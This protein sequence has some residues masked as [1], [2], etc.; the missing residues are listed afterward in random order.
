MQKLE[1]MSPIFD[2]LRRRRPSFVDSIAIQFPELEAVAKG[3]R[4]LGTSSDEP[5]RVDLLSTPVFEIGE[6]AIADA[7]TDLGELV[8]QLSKKTKVLARIRLV[9][10]IMTALTT[11]GVLAAVLKEQ[12]MLEVLTAVIA[13]LCAMASLWAIYIEDLSGGEGTVTKARDAAS[14]GIG[15]LAEAEGLLTLAKIMKDGTKALAALSAVNEVAA[16]SQILRAR[17]GLA[18]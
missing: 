18:I 9:S 5:V 2:M 4:L 16:Q 17:F 12:G 7:R 15:K 10:G 3:K 13:F 11:A 6:A 1:Q 8:Q 14:N